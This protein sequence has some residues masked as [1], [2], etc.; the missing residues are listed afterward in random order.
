MT[1]FCA[2]CLKII[3]TGSFTTQILNFDYH[4]H[5]IKCYKCGNSLWD[6]AFTKKID[7]KLYCDG[8]CSNQILPSLNSSSYNH[9]VHEKEKQDLLYGS[10]NP[11]RSYKNKYIASNLIRLNNNK[12]LSLVSNDLHN[13]NFYLKSIR[14]AKNSQFISESSSG[15]SSPDMI[16]QVNRDSQKFNIENSGNRKENKDNRNDLEEDN[17]NQSVCLICNK[18][19]DKNST[20]NYNK[21]FYHRECLKCY[22]CKIE[23]YRMKKIMEYDQKLC[24]EP[25]YYEYFGPKCPKCKLTVTP[26]MLFSK[27][28]N[29]TYHKVKSFIVDLVLKLLANELKKIYI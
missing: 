19:I 28:E 2:N 21:K 29:D 12:N 24:C 13:P 9:S 27:H 10:Y 1:R 22:I 5:C 20:V 23:L 25:C 16:E 15:T 8:I 3:I 17:Q 14:D 26:Y 6:K 11:N 7:G 4:T 18:L